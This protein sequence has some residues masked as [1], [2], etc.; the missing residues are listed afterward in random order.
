MRSFS[1]LVFCVAGKFNYSQ[2]YSIEGE[3]FPRVLVLSALVRRQGECITQVQNT[4]MTDKSPKRLHHTISHFGFHLFELLFWNLAAALISMC[5]FS[6]RGSFPLLDEI[7][8]MLMSSPFWFT[9][10][11]LCT[12]KRQLPCNLHSQS[13]GI[14]HI[15][16]LFLLEE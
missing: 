15:K 8:F 10:L 1:I 13:V 7:K 12:A 11:T 3:I 4:W 14:S 6:W 5:S 2:F 9:R 16:D